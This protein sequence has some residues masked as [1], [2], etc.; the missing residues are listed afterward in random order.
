MSRLT[1]MMDIWL[2]I[3]DYFKADMITIDDYLNQHNPDYIVNQP[4]MLTHVNLNKAKLA[5]IQVKIR[6]TE[7]YFIEN[8]V[9][10]EKRYI[11]QFNEFYIEIVYPIVGEMTI[12]TKSGKFITDK[13]DLVKDISY[14][15]FLQE[16]QSFYHELKMAL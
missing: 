3:H 13:Y 11:K 6:G 12:N 8:E 5:D 10:C 4:N 9:L 1:D 14:D 15:R 7:H 16:Y 2:G